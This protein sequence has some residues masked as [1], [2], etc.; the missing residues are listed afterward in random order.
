MLVELCLDLVDANPLF[1][2][3][4]KGGET[5][6]KTLAAYLPK[7][8]PAFDAATKILNGKEFYGGAS[9]AFGDFCFLALVDNILGIEPGALAAHPVIHAWYTR[10]MALPAVATYMVTSLSSCFKAIPYLTSLFTLLMISHRHHVQLIIA[11]LDPCYTPRHNG[12]Q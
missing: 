3:Y 6:S 11:C 1:V 2:Y 10:C 4:E 8:P 12:K 9:P 5:H 7:L